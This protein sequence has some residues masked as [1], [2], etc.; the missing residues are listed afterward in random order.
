MFRRSF[1]WQ[2]PIITS[3]ASTFCSFKKSESSATEESFSVS[4]VLSSIT[5]KNNNNNNDGDDTTNYVFNDAR[6][7]GDKVKFDLVGENTGDQTW[8]DK[9]KTVE[10]PLELISSWFQKK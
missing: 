8:E 2:L 6:I 3:L 9:N 5:N 10:V 4:D 7:C 1:S